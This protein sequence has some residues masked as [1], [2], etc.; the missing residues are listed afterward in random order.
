MLCQSV[1]S[2]RLEAACE[3]SNTSPGLIFQ[4]SD[5]A[6]QWEPNSADDM[7]LA[8]TQAEI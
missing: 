6:E 5:R 8:I 7:G 4:A 1:S 3:R 2:S